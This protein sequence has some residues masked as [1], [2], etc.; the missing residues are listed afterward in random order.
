[1]IK[2]ELNDG[3]VHSMGLEEMTRWCCLMEAI[4]SIENKCEER[5]IDMDKV[6]WVKPLAIQKYMDERYHAMLHD[7]KVEYQAGS[8]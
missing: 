6:D 5:G 4:S 3:R 7:V 8:I 1:M 2:F